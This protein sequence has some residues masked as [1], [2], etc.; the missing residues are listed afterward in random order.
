METSET[1]SEAVAAALRIARA[2]AGRQRIV[3]FDGHCHGWLNGVFAST[4]SDPV[5]SV[6]A[7][8]GETIA[9]T[10]ASGPTSVCSPGPCVVGV[11]ISAVTGT[12]SPR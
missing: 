5:R 2:G 10:A 9:S 1:G 4:A 11:S 3:K 6:P 8:A 12:T 7:D